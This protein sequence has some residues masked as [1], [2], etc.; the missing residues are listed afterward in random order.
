ML[1]LC[2][3][4]CVFYNSKALCLEIVYKNTTYLAKSRKTPRVRL[5]IVRK[6]YGNILIERK[7]KLYAKSS[8]VKIMVFSKIR[9]KMNDDYQRESRWA[10]DVRRQLISQYGTSSARPKPDGIQ[11]DGTYIFSHNHNWQIITSFPF[12]NLFDEHHW[13]N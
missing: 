5:T 8:S 7:S 3:H 11:M 10:A 1:E 12:Y 6:P 9:W 2:S 13:I 4:Q